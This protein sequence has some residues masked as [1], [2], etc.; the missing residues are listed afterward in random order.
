MNQITACADYKLPQILRKLEILEYAPI[1]VEKID[2]EIEIK[3]G[4]PEETEIRANAIWAVEFIKEEVKKRNPQIMSF[5]INDDLWLATQEKF[6]GD[7]PCHRTRTTA[8]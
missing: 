8:Y 4:S 7:K 1:L 6:D 2:N 5:Q 3:K